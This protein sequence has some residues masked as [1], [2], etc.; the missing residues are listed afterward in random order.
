MGNIFVNTIAFNVNLVC[1]CAI[2]LNATTVDE[3]IKT[4]VSKFVFF[5]IPYFT[6]LISSLK[7]VGYEY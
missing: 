4:G 5:V 2:L 7:I 3:I 1:V 6:S